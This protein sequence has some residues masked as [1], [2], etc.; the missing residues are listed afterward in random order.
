MDCQSASGAF[1]VAAVHV[2]PSFSHCIDHLIEL[3]HELTVP[4]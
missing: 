2:L 3:D 4:C 1:F